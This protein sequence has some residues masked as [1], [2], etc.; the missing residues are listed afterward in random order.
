MLSKK[1]CKR[2]VGDYCPTAPW[3]LYDDECWDDGDVNCPDKADENEALGRPSTAWVS[4]RKSPPEWCPHVFEHAVA[5][6]VKDAM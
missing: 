3:S 2:C 6:G 1:V 5:A 4:P